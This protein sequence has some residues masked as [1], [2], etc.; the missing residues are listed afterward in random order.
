M[1]RVKS[2]ELRDACIKFSMIML[3]IFGKVERQDLEIWP[4]WKQCFF[5]FWFWWSLHGFVIFL[6]LWASTNIMC[7][8]PQKR[9]T[10]FAQTISPGCRK[11]FLRLEVVDKVRSY[12]RLFRERT[13]RLCNRASL[14]II[15]RQHQHYTTCDSSPLCP[16]PN[17]SDR[18]AISYDARR[19]AGTQR[20]QEASSHPG[21]E[22][23]TRTASPP[24]RPGC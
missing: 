18:W 20:P 8:L 23:S 10:V 22:G 3:N 24:T 12:C 4:C 1:A 16:Q 13:G 7:C 17:P 5:K 6:N 9:L 14:I 15:N 11:L 2:C 19:A 21:L